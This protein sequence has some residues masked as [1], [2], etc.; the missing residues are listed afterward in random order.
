MVG[1]YP[2]N[3]L[4]AGRRQPLTSPIAAAPPSLC[5][6][7]ERR[8]EWERPSQ[9]M[10][11]HH[12]GAEAFKLAGGGERARDTPSGFTCLCTRQLFCYVQR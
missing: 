7:A 6:R 11:Y 2:C 5:R 1:N 4:S 9:Q 10:E 8:D 12:L 3:P